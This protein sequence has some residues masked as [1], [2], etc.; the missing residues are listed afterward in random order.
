MNILEAAKSGLYYEVKRCLEERQPVHVVDPSGFTPLH[1]A[2]ANG[3]TFVA[4]LLL[5]HGADVSKKGSRLD[6]LPLHLA[7]LNNHAEMIDL[8]IQHG[9]KYDEPNNKGSN[10]LDIAIAIEDNFDAVIALV[11]NG[12]T[13]TNDHMVALK[14][15]LCNSL[16]NDHTAFV[17]FIVKQGF[18]LKT[19]L[20]GPESMMMG[21]NLPL[22]LA[23]ANASPNCLRY[24]IEQ[25]P[26]ALKMPSF[27][28]GQMMG[29]SMISFMKLYMPTREFFNANQLFFANQQGAVITKPEELRAL[30]P[31]AISDGVASISYDEA[32]DRF[33]LDKVMYGMIMLDFDASGQLKNVPDMLTNLKACIQ[34]LIEHD[35]AIN[36]EDGL[37][38]GST[39]TSALIECPAQIIQCFIDF[40]LTFTG[41]E[42]HTA[43]ATAPADVVSVIIESGA[44]ILWE[45]KDGQNAIAWMMKADNDLILNDRPNLIR[46]MENKANIPND[47]RMFPVK[48]EPM[49]R[50]YRGTLTQTPN[51]NSYCKAGQNDDPMDVDLPAVDK[52]ARYFA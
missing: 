25:D 52:Y 13:I 27:S 40:G 18:P 23:A 3:H 28:M 22:V 9:A 11:K 41:E 24:I 6:I 51:H 14:E 31:E 4:E 15:M 7:A 32:H 49:L 45:N 33:Y 26:K 12:A 38:T 21:Y 19:F 44:D 48:E 30:I 46:L 1:W 36:A 8:L 16:M 2:A 39:T 35:Q 37:M 50:M 34:I 42:L 29:M 5:E 10:A 20:A 17:E 47:Q 43:I